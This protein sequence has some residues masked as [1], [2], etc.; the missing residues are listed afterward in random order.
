MTF[1]GTTQT[2]EASVRF[3]AK[4]ALVTGICPP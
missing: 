2:F 4:D 1:G 3:R